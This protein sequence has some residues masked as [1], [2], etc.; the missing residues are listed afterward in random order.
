[1]IFLDEQHANYAT[2]RRVGRQKGLVVFGTLLSVDQTLDG[3]PAAFLP[4]T[5]GEA[6]LV[7]AVLPRA[8]APTTRAALELR[9]HAAQRRVFAQSADDGDARLQGTP[10]ERAFGVAAIDDQPHGFSGLFHE[11]NDPLHQSRRQLQLGGEPRP[12]TALG[13]RGHGLL[14][15]IQQRTQRQRQGTPPR[16][17]QGQRNRDPHVSVEKRLIGRTRRGIVMHIRALDLRAVP[18]GGRIVDHQQQPLGKR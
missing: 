8:T 6:E 18:L 17:S 12:T 10:Q 1:M 7:R 9:R 14:A 13:N 11:R 15:N 16:M 2:D 3:L 5:L 4:G